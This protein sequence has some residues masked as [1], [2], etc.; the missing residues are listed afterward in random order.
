[1]ILQIKKMLP[2]SFLALL[3]GIRAKY[4]T[5]I[6][7]KKPYL[8]KIKYVGFDLYYTR[9][10]GLIQRIRLG[11]TSRIYEKELSEAIL[12]EVNRHKYPIFYDVGANIGLISLYIASNKPESTIYAFEPG[13]HQSQLFNI[14]ILAN[15][16]TNKIHLQTIALS[17]ETR[18]LEFHTHRN[19]VHVGADGLRP[20]NRGGGETEKIIVQ[21]MTLDAWAQKN[22]APN[23][24][25]IKIDVEGAELL[26]LKGMGEILEKHRPIIF[27]EISIPNLKAYPYS[28][29]DILEYLDTQRYNLYSLSGKQCKKDTIEQDIL[30][31][32]TFIARP[33]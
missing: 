8:N 17:N 21:G 10:T 29:Q 7:S 33:Q 18:I 2:L 20:T 13:P 16:L 31:D 15:E 32:D 27:M 4:Y 30:T 28:A 22:K 12:T 14:T 25:V 9:G 6:D 11:S 19:K 1:M 23:P 5:F 26:V 24:H 3:R